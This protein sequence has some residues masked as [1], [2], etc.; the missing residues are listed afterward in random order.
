MLNERE[1]ESARRGSFSLPDVSLL[2]FRPL[3]SPFTP[4]GTRGR[5]KRHALP[6]FYFASEG[7]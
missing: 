3:H 1:K 6:F 2:I 5:A 7:S 4:L